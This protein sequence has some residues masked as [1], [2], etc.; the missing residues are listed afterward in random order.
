MSVWICSSKIQ[1]SAQCKVRLATYVQSG[2]KLTSVD[3]RFR[4]LR[5]Y[6][7]RVVCATVASSRWASISY[8]VL[9]ASKG[10]T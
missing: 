3:C 1:D 4:S 6:V 9:V 7:C 10:F 5:S 8:I 2:S